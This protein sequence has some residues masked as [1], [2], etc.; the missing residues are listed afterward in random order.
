MTDWEHTPTP[1]AGGPLLGGALCLIGGGAG[2][3]VLVPG[4]GWVVVAWFSA[5]VV[6]LGA[7]LLTVGGIKLLRARRAATKDRA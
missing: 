3:V 2:L 5:G 1:G 7:V 6:L 4:S